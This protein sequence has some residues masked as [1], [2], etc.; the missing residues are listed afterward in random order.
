MVASYN[1]RAIKF[2]EKYGFCKTGISIE[3][4]LSEKYK[5]IK[6]P[7]LEM[8]RRFEFNLDLNPSFTT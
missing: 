7:E 2:Y 4:T 3:A 1:Y 6:M 5:D 8:V